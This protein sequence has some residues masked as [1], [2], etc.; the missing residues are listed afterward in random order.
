M[1]SIP[2]HEAMRELSRHHHHAL[3]V[4][5]KIRKTLIEGVAPEVVEQLRKDLKHF[6]VTG[7]QE[8]FREE[9]EILLPAYARY[10]SPRHEEIIEMLIEHAQIRA[11]V[12]A[13]DEGGDHDR[14]LVTCI[15]ELGDVLEKHVRREERVIFP[16]MEA[17]LPE[18]V[19]KK[20]APYFHEFHENKQCEKN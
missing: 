15:Q 8:H 4:V 14:D 2:R 16:M 10:A 13:I 19:L 18:D 5:L 20:L 12:A 3:T 7:G 6:W 11:L 1:K 9:E 17:A